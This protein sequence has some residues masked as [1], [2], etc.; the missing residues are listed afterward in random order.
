[1]CVCVCV[2]V[3]LIGKG[4]AELDGEIALLKTEV[5]ACNT[6]LAEA[7]RG[8]LAADTAMQES[9]AAAERMEEELGK[10][11][12]TRS[13]RFPSTKV[14]I[15]T[16]KVLLGA[17]KALLAAEKAAREQDC[18]KLQERIDN[19][20]KQNVDLLASKKK[21]LAAPAASPAAAVAASSR[22]VYI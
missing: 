4:T 15:L 17:H 12:E 8:K 3:C 6:K 19:L 9:K 22:Y 1:M 10:K 18:K 5:E 13:S 14:Q 16:Q 20:L 7:A 21:N 11:K 2:C